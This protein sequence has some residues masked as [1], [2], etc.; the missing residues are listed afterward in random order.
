MQVI[1]LGDD[2]GIKVDLWQLV[3][4]F[5]LLA[6]LLHGL[7]VGEYAYLFEADVHG[8]EGKAGDG[9]VGVRLVPVAVHGGVVHGQQLQ[10]ALA[11]LGSPVDHKGDVGEFAYTETFL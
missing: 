6:E 9:V 4:L 1:P 10:E 2:Y 3:Q 11:C 5:L 7:F 8:V